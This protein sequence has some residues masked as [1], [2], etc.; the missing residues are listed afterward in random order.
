MSTKQ[1]D[2][3]TFYDWTK[4]YAIYCDG[5]EHQ[6]HRENPI[7]FKDKQLYFRGTRNS[8]EQF[9]YLDEKYDFYNGDTIVLTGVSAGGMA[10]YE[11][12]NYV[13][14]HTKKAKFYALPDRGFFITDF[15]SDI[16]DMKVLLSYAKNLVELVG[17]DE[18]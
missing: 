8:L 16:V 14:D 17:V 2:N 7:T 12:S 18:E 6:G 4:I 3:P 11:W 1:E 10:T 5:S 15:Y 13:L 9:H